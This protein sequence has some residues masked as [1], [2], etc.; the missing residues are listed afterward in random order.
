MMLLTHIPVV[1]KKHL[2][3]LG[4]GCI[5]VR[6]CR[7]ERVGITLSRGGHH[8]LKGNASGEDKRRGLDAASPQ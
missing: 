6:S 2:Q 8:P 4:A 5:P 3:C 7:V 1:L